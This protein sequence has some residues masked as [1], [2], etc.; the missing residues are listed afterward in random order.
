MCRAKIKGKK[1]GM[2][3]SEGLSSDWP[4]KDQS[5]IVEWFIFGRCASAYFDQLVPVL[6]EFRK[7]LVLISEYTLS[8]IAWQEE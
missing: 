8:Q 2:F 3:F 5:T 4:L 6:L 1:K 7:R